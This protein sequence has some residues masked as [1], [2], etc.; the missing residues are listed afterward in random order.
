[1]DTTWLRLTMMAI[2]GV[3]LYMGYRLFCDAPRV[4]ADAV[5][6]FAV[7]NAMLRNFVAGALLAVFG[8]GILF[9]EARAFAGQSKEAHRGWNRNRPAQQ[10]SYE[11]PRLHHETTVQRF[12]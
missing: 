12:A 8:L 10:G 7:R 11:A 1:M 4:S 5:R 2:G 3:S 6:G 9:T